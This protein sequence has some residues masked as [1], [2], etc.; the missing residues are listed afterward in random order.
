MYSN[1]IESAGACLKAIAPQDY[2]PTVG[3]NLDDRIKQV[4]AEL[5]RLKASRETL[6]P[7]LQMR[8]R[9]IRDAMSY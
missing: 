5:A 4:E 1:S 9:D 3:E 6:G 2:N 7:L 8:I